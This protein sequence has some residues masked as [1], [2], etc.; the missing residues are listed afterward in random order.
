MYLNTPHPFMK[1]ILGVEAPV[2]FPDRNE[3]GDKRLDPKENV[4]KLKEKIRKQRAKDVVP[5]QPYLLMAS[6]VG[7][8]MDW[9][10]L[11]A[12]LKKLNP[13]LI[14][15][16]GGVP[17]AI[18]IRIVD[19]EHAPWEPDTK[20]IGGFMRTVLTEWDTA[21]TDEW[22]IANAPKRGWRTVV[23]MLLAGGYARKIDAD[24]IFG[25]ASGNQRSDIWGKKIQS[26]ELNLK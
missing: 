19:P 10:E 15:L 9:R 13:N 14:M 7:K 16:D 24:R 12:K 21:T 6:A 18:Q 26:R 20:Y 3:L 11:V 5:E 4:A 22:G 2:V 8:P 25:E 1:N 23:L 17:G